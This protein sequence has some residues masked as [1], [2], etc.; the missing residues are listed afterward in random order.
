MELPLSSDKDRNEDKNK[1]SI[2]PQILL[3]SSGELTPFVLQLRLK[4]HSSY[5]RAEGKIT[6]SMEFKRMSDRPA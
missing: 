6:G 5:F 3:L 4:N 1:K 2:Q